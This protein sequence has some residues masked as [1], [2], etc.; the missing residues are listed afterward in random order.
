MPCANMSFHLTPQNIIKAVD[1]LLNQLQIPHS[2]SGS[3]RVL[4]FSTRTGTNISTDI[5]YK[6]LVGHI[7]LPFMNVVQNLLDAFCPY[8]D[9]AGMTKEANADD[10]VPLQ[11]Q[12]LLSLQESIFEP[13]AAAEGDDFIFFYIVFLNLKYFL[14][15]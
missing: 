1:F 13:G 3:F 4:D 11:S 5:D 10:N 8:F 9:V 2:L 12:A 6:D 15:F 14:S 7:N